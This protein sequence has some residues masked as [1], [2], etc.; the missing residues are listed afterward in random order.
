[1]EKSYNR[2]AELVSANPIKWGF[3][4]LLIIILVL[5]SGYYQRNSKWQR[6][7]ETG[8]L[9]FSKLRY[10]VDNGDTITI[11]GYLKDNSVI[12]GFLC[13]AG[14]IHFD[15]NWEP[16]LFCLYSGLRVNNVELGAGTWVSMDQKNP[17]MG[18]VYPQK[19][20]VSG[21]QC[22]GGGGAKGIQTTFYST[23]ELREFFP[24]GEVVIGEIRCKGG[25]FNPV[26]LHQNGNIELCTLK[27]EVEIDGRLL[28]KGDVLRF[29]AQ[30]NLVEYK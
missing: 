17:Y 18:V 14:W 29:D 2:A 5:C 19:T 6:N 21:F 7:V 23:G 27:E 11:I 26:K 28:K 22:M 4:V 8:A 24:P 10:I 3:A 20:V 25:V 15:K 13:K 16:K 9:S 1:M 30:G 12:N